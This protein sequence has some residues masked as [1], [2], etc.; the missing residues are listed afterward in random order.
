MERAQRLVADAVGHGGALDWEHKKVFEGLAVDEIQ[1][2]TGQEIE[3]L[4]AD[5]MKFNPFRVCEEVSF[6]LEGVTGPGGYLESYVAK[7]LGELFF[8][9]KE[10]LDNCLSEPNNIVPGCNYYRKLQQFI[11]NHCR[12]GKKYIECLKFECERK[13][14]TR[15]DFCESNEWIGPACT[16]IL[17]PM[18]NESRLYHYKHVR[19]TPAQI[20][21]CMMEIDD[22]QP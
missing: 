8:F 20:N 22:L 17:P 9:D 11:D 18:P 15:C 21:G 5:R 14:G 10:Y 4:E 12:K 1:S 13:N 7:E 6:R 16:F 3:D 19:D 2:L